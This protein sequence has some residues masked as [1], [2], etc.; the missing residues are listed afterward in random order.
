MILRFALL[1]YGEV[2]SA[3]DWYND[4]VTVI[5][6]PG[7]REQQPPP[8]QRA[9]KRS[10]KEAAAEAGGCGGCSGGEEAEEDAPLHSSRRGRKRKGP[11][12]GV[13]RESPPAE[14]KPP[15]AAEV[16]RGRAHTET[17]WPLS[18]GFV[19]LQGPITQECQALNLSLRTLYGSFIV[20]RGRGGGGWGGGCHAIILA[21]WAPAA[22]A[23][24]RTSGLYIRR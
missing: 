7:E 12:K 18:A 13:R 20:G 8:K 11:G 21:F 3:V 14:L 9:R 4:F 10:R 1:Q 24:P 19:V 6:E 23:Q 22:C 16:R 17:L 5:V 15:S 2:F